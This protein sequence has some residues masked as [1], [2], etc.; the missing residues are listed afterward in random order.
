MRHQLPGSPAKRC[1]RESH[2]VC[3]QEPPTHDIVEPP[4]GGARCPFPTC[5]AWRLVCFVR[6]MN[7]AAKFVCR[8]ADRL[9][10]HARE[11]QCRSVAGALSNCLRGSSLACDRTCFALLEGQFF[12]LATST[13]EDCQPCESSCSDFGGEARVRTECLGTSPGIC[14]SCAAGL[15]TSDGRACRPCE[16]GHTCMDGCQQPIA[17]GMA[18]PQGD[19]LQC[20]SGAMS[21]EACGSAATWC[22][23]GNRSVVSFGHYTTC[24]E[25]EGELCLSTKRSAQQPCP[26]GHSCRNGILAPCPDGQFQNLTRQ[27]RCFDVSAGYYFRLSD[28]L[29]VGQEQCDE[30]CVWS[31]S[32]SLA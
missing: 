11:L 8:R 14:T 7:I 19:V 16:P 1:L 25:S 2:S 29:R 32:L 26:V 31:I 6:L 17:P 18:C 22:V 24:V 23:L 30:A 27:E 13:C 15:H 5:C 21:L 20:V 3:R 4:C 10:H 12:N 28:G 9:D